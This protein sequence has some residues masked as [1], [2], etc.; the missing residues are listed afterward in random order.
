MGPAQA[1]ENLPPGATAQVLFKPTRT[2]VSP[3]NLYP[4]AVKVET[5]AGSAEWREELHANVIARGTVAI[6][7]K[8]ED[9]TK[10]KAVPQ[11]FFGAATQTDPAV[12]YM[13]PYEEL[14]KVSAQGYH[15]YFAAAYDEANFYCMLRLND[16]KP[17]YA[18]SMVKGEWYKMYPGTDDVV[19]A[20]APAAP[21]MNAPDMLQIAFDFMPNHD[22]FLPADHPMHHAFPFRQTDYEYS[23]YPTKENAAELWRLY[24]PNTYWQCH[25]APFSPNPKSAQGVPP[26]YKAVTVHDGKGWTFELAIP[27]S[28]MPLLRKHL[29][30]GKPIRFGYKVRRDGGGYYSTQMRSACKRN[31][32]SWHPDYMCDNWSVETPWA[33]E[34]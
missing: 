5:P 34:K 9:W 1:F 13:R 24:A 19:Y 17:Q 6:D 15:G 26:K 2:A 28:E 12:R 4:F 27:W 25:Y 22:D 8:L 32:P 14:V 23:L 18:V 10:I 11:T 21:M 16:P 31:G 29:K 20:K 33:F 7:G 3:Q 30:T